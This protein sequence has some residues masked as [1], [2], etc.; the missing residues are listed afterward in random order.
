MASLEPYSETI[1]DMLRRHA[2]HA[3]IA[4][5]LTDIGAGRGCSVMSVQRFCNVHNLK[6]VVSDA[7]LEI[8]V[9][10]A[11]E[12]VRFFLKPNSDDGLYLNKFHNHLQLL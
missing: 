7:Q 8:A 4:Q 2:T 10:S 1:C 12:E 3:D 6:R 5:H 11:I 9:S